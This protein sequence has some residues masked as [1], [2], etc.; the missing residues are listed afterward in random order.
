MIS[1]GGEDL[2][3]T[4]FGERLAKLRLEKG[5]SARY[6]SLTLGQN[7]NYINKIENKTAYPS[8]QMFFEICEFLEIS[9]KDFFDDEIS[10]PSQLNELIERSRMLGDDMLQHFTSIVGEIIVRK[11]NEKK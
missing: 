4:D 11:E 7:A 2:K 1:R 8:M 10:N 5:V 6:M 3:L 9:Q